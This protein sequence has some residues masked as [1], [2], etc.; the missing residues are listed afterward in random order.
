[1][2]SGNDKSDKEHL[3]KDNYEQDASEKYDCEKGKLKMRIM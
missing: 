1:M 3:K 2:K